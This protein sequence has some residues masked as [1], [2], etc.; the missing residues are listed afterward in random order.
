MLT[1]NSFRSRNPGVVLLWTF[2][3]FILIQVHQYVG[4]LLSSLMCGVSFEAA[5][6]GEFYNECCVL[7]QGLTAAIIGIPLSLG[8]A[9]YLWR[10]NW[11]WIRFR[12]NGVLFGYGILLGLILPGFILGL[13]FSLGM[14]AVVATPARYGIADVFS[15][16]VGT[17]GFTL[18]VAFSEELV[19]RGMAVREWAA[20]MGW[21]LATLFGGLYFGFAHLIGLLTRITGLEAVWIIVSAV[22]A[23]VLLTAMYI[24]SKSLWLPIGFHFGWNLCLQLFF[25]T[26]VSGNE[27]NFGLFRTELS[28]PTFLTGGTFGIEASVITY[29]CYAVAAILLLRYSRGG[30]PV[31]LEP[32]PEPPRSFDCSDK[33]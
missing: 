18:F 24:R 29:V 9:K 2:G 23:G 12:F 1:N 11:Q 10:R 21:P 4:I 33:N 14:A 5:I 25:G 13:L 3:L 22:I 26:V 8:I 31:L 27:S 6:E 15:I 16:I 19:F 17:V 20:K 7:W 32:G 28:G 30:R